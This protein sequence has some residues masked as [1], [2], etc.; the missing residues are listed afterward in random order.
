MK[1]IT[2]TVPITTSLATTQLYDAFVP[3]FT[4]GELGTYLGFTALF[5]RT[6]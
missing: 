4:L 2:L 1:G 5:I 3:V 6:A